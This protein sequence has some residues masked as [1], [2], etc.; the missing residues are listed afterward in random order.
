MKQKNKTSETKLEKIKKG[1]KLANLRT[2]HKF[3]IN[4]GF[5]KS[6]RT[7]TTTLALIEKESKSSLFHSKRHVSIRKNYIWTL[8]SKFQSYSKNLFLLK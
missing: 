4:F 2:F 1:K 8:P 5:H 3:I 7:S 6:P